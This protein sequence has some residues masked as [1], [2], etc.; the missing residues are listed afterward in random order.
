MTST[1]DN[2]DDVPGSHQSGSGNDP[3]FIRRWHVGF[4]RMLMGAL[5]LKPFFD[6]V[7]STSSMP[8]PPWYSNSENYTELAMG[9]S[10]L[11]AGAVGI[12][13]AIN[14]SNASLIMACAMKDGTLLPPSRPSA[15]IDAVYLPRGSQPFLVDVGR[16]FQG[17]S[18]PT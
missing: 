6:N 14:G 7:W 4:D 9:L 3:N 17:M 1:R 15:Y 12:G 10:I 11:G 18:S 5:K 13:D 8:G 16:V 2:I